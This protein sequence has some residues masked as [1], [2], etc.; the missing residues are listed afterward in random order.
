[1]MNLA[2]TAKKPAVI[3]KILVARKPRRYGFL[4]REA[5]K[6]HWTGNPVI[7]A[8]AHIFMQPCTE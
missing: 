3:E 6:N 4:D 7:A 1:M 2:L 5:P 8:A